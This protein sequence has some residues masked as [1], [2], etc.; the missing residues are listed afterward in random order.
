MPDGAA[1]EAASG[2]SCRPGELHVTKDFSGRIRD[3]VSKSSS[4]SWGIEK[5]VAEECC[6]HTRV[7]WWNGCSYYPQKV[8]PVDES[9]LF[10]VHCSFHSSQGVSCCY[11]LEVSVNSSNLCC[12]LVHTKLT[13]LKSWSQYW[14]LYHITFSTD[15]KDLLVQAPFNRKLV[16]SLCF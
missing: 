10:Q 6:S 7:V 5:K 1:V 4:G 13:S 11:W 9:V 8:S 12:G 15:Y 14:R 16:L 3:A 2:A